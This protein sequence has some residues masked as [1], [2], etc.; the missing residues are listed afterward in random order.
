MSRPSFI[1]RRNDP[2]AVADR[3]AWGEKAPDYD[4]QTMAML[5]PILQLSEQEPIPAEARAQLVHADLT[6]NFV[7]SE[8]QPPGIIDIT[9]YW[10]P[11]GFAEAVIWVDSIWHPAAAVPED[12]SRPGMLA[13]VLRALA[14]RMA[15]QPEQVAAGMKQADEAA[16]TL[17]KLSNAAD[18]LLAPWLSH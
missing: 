4:A 16:A 10:R 3:I 13:F 6:G 7:L 9:P 18:H 11:E 17:R 8:G 2:W 1:E 14:R 12:F 5:L 15:E